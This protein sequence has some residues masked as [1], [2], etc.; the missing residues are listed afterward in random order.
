M[1][2]YLRW[3]F[4]NTYYSITFRVVDK[5]KDLTTYVNALDKCR[6]PWWKFEP[7]VHYN[8]DGKQWEVWFYNESCVSRTEY[9]T[10]TVHRDNSDGVGR[11]RIVGL[12][13]YESTINSK[14]N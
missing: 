3:A 10:C 2:K 6:W 7:H 4:W 9:I 12:T 8:E 1:F 13:I 5:P 11:G 14:P